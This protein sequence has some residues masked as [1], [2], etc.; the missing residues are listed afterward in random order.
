L[1]A[2]AESHR[3]LT[4]P[5]FTRDRHLPRSFW[6]DRH[7]P[8]G[9]YRRV[10][11]LTTTAEFLPEIASGQANLAMAERPSP[12]WW[13]MCQGR[14]HLPPIRSIAGMVAR[15]KVPVAC[16]QSTSVESPDQG[17]AMALTSWGLGLGRTPPRLGDSRG[18]HRRSARLSCW[19]PA[20]PRR[21]LEGEEPIQYGRFHRPRRMWA[22]RAWLNA[23]CA[24]QGDRQHR[25]PCHHPR[26][27]RHGRS[28]RE[29]Q[30]LKLAWTPPA[31]AF[32]GQCQLRPEYFRHHPASFRRVWNAAM[33]V[34]LVIDPPTR[35]RAGSARLP[36][37]RR[38]DGAAPAWW[39]S[40]VGAPSKKT[41][42]T[43]PAM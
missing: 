19:L 39:W 31:F 43:M 2:A 35:H 8:G 26:H 11:S 7:L 42:T 25:F 5:G 16:W 38:E 33:S 10:W 6:G 22:V 12:W 1:S 29:G 36:G 18:R 13:S 27:D 37:D 41:A 20:P 30:N 4:S 15:Q 21:K 3:S 23:I 32:A 17:L 14:A 9:R 40:T 28:S 34:L 24:G